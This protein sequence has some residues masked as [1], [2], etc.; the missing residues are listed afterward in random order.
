MLNEF[1]GDGPIP[2]SSFTEELGTAE[3]QK[4]PRIASPYDAFQEFLKVLSS[5]ENYDKMV[6]CME[7]GLPIE[8]IANTVI[9]NMVAGGV[10]SYDVGL[11]MLPEIVRVMEAVAKDLEIDYVS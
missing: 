2:G 3:W 5:G 10:T 1:L 6:Y 4:P 9:N 7:E 11:L 8:G